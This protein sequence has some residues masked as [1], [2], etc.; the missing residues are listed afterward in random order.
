MYE[1]MYKV[2]NIADREN[3]YKKSSLPSVVSQNSAWTCEIYLFNL[4]YFLNFLIQQLIFEN[5][6]VH[7]L[8]SKF[9]Y[10]QFSGL[11]LYLLI[12]FYVIHYFNFYNTMKI[13]I[14]KFYKD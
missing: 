13:L 2:Y 10:I 6:N 9:I 3:F 8:N 1:R 7:F 12:N 5:R 4:I 14:E 11:N